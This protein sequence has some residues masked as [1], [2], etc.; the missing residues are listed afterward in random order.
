MAA[1]AHRARPP[2][3]PKKKKKEKMKAKKR[4]TG[5]GLDRLS[6]GEGARHRRSQT[7]VVSRVTTFDNFL[8]A[9]LRT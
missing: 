3:A 2:P 9:A 1:S 4:K 5:Q 7:A 8:K 6:N